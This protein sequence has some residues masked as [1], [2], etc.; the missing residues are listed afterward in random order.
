M[1]K[2]SLLLKSLFDIVDVDD[3]REWVDQTEDTMVLL[4]SPHQTP[5]LVFADCGLS[6]ISPSCTR[7]GALRS[8]EQDRKHPWS[9]GLS[10]SSASGK[11]G[12]DGTLAICGGVRVLEELQRSCED[13]ERV[14]L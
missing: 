2:L 3:T 12:S 4:A 7:F 1:G 9:T 13:C 14:E 5:P 6:A 11:N 10:L 8:V